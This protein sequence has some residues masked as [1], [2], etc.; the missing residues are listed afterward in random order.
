MNVENECT[1]VKQNEVGKNETAYTYQEVL[2][3]IASV[4]RC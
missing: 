1:E 2:M 4:L 3:Q